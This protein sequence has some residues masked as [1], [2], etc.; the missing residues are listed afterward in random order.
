MLYGRYSED[1]SLLFLYYP[2]SMDRYLSSYIENV[3]LLGNFFLEK[4]DDEKKE[5]I[6]FFAGCLAGADEEFFYNFQE[7]IILLA[8][9]FLKSLELHPPYLSPPS[10][11]NTAS[12]TFPRWSTDGR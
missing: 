10:P 8:H 12:H 4:I 6:I 7:H 5:S 11:P 9:I 1:Q 2:L 3:H